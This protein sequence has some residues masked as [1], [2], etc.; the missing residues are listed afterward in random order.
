MTGTR[1]DVSGPMKAILEELQALMPGSRKLAEKQGDPRLRARLGW[2]RHQ[3]HR[4]A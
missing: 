4:L 3:H 2:S 1:A